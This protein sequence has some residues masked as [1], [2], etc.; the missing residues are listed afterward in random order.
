[1]TAFMQFVRRDEKFALVHKLKQIASKKIEDKYAE[2]LADKFK[3]V[4]ANGF[5]AQQGVNANA[6]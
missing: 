5:N 2:F 1:M 6:D 4:L 3:L